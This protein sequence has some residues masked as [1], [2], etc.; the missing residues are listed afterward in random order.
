MAAAEAL[1]RLANYQAGATLTIGD[2][3]QTCCCWACRPGEQQRAATTTPIELSA[4]AIANVT[5]MNA[6]AA[7]LQYGSFSQ[8]THAI[9]LEDSGLNLAGF[10]ASGNAV[11]TAYVMV[12]DATLTVAQAQVLANDDVTIG[13]NHLTVA[14][15][16]GNL[17]DVLSNGAVYALATTLSLP[18]PTIAIAQQIE[19]LA[20]NSK[21]TTGGYAL[22]VTGSAADLL[23]LGSAALLATSLMLTG[24]NN[25]VDANGLLQLPSLAA[26]SARIT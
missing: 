26:S 8:N 20:A 17:Q 3:L 9:T 11:P 5:Q 7:L 19:T 24:A 23:G 4:D 25:N 2:T 21:F 6:L 12:G 18:G 13:T 14:D 16:P 10:V 1:I 22:T 15:T